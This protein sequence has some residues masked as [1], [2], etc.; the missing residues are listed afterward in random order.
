MHTEVKGPAVADLQSAFDDRWTTEGGRLPDRPPEADLPPAPAGNQTVRIVPHTG[1]QDENLKN[2]YLRAIDTAQSSIK[3]EDP[4]FT[5]PEIMQHLEAAARRGVD[6]SCV[7][8]AQNNVKMAEDAGRGDYAALMAAGVK[9][10]EYQPTMA[11]EKVCAIDGKFATIGSSNL[12]PRSLDVNDE[13]NLVSLDPTLAGQLTS[14]IDADIAKSTRVT[15][16]P[17][18]FLDGLLDRPIIGNQL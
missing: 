18:S 2:M 3:I 5:D 10:Y 4:Y 11:H 14:A 6:V 8:P 9:V 7:W 15:T 17:K 1:G 16:A 13:L 12:D